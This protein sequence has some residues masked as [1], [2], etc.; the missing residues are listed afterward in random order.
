[1]PSPALTKLLL[2]E[3]H[4]HLRAGHWQ[5][6]LQSLVRA[7]VATG[8]EVTVVSAEDVDGALRQEL[9]ALGCRCLSLDSNAS[10]AVKLGVRALMG[11]EA[12]A[13]RSGLTRLSRDLAAL[14]RAALEAGLQ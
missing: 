3:P 2:V 11:L 5:G 1:V 13:R 9:T 8:V 10:S 6:A 14:R 4:A 12:T 7:P